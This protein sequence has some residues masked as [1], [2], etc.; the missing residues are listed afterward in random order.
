MTSLLTRKVRMP[1]PSLA[2][3]DAARTFGSTFELQKWGDILRVP[4]TPHP[5]ETPQ[6]GE[7]SSGDSD[8][9]NMEHKKKTKKAAP[10]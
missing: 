4:F 8:G 5:H 6:A 3:I 1:I 7:A 9:G 10:S 2:Q